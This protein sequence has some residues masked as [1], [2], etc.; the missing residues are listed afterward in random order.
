MPKSSLA[1]IA[2][3]S[4]LSL[5]SLRGAEPQ[6]FNSPEEVVGKPFPP[7]KVE[8]LVPR[9][10]LEGKAR[11]VEF[12]ATWCEPCRRSIPHLNEIYQKYKEQGL[13]IVGITDETKA[14]VEAFKAKQP[15]DY[16]LAIDAAGAFRDSLG[17]ED[18]PQA[19]VLNKKGLVIWQGNPLDLKKATIKKALS[20]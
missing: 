12:W 2:L 18:I 13:E 17:F 1:A 11:V 8:F 19:F 9:P 6:R 4:A 5:L 15:I 14:D 20:E 10:A 3:F 16:P 7:L